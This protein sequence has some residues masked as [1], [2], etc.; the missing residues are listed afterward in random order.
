M[1]NVDGLPNEAG[2]IRE[3]VD[4]TLCY[5]KHS[6]RVQFAVTKLGK[7]KV[8]LGY[9]WLRKHNPEVDWVTQKVNLSRCPRVCSTCRAEVKAQRSAD[10][11][12]SKMEQQCCLGPFPKV[13]VEDIDDEEDEKYNHTAKDS[14]PDDNDDNALED[15]DRIFTTRFQ[16][17]ADI[18][19]TSTVS[20]RL[21]EAHAKNSTPTGNIPDWV[22]EYETVF[23]KESFDSLPDRRS[24]DHAIE[25]FPDA[26]P[27]N[28]KV[29]RSLP[30]SRRSLTASLKRDWHLVGFGHP[31]LPWEEQIPAPSDQ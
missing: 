25:L 6:K 28:C 16:S 8:I 20:Q 14:N 30:M 7:E 17:S 2:F 13:V 15:G 18:R 12:A 11:R 9:T 10:S 24:W 3:I 22:K 21:A 29:Y 19:A 23:A 1:F 4:V 27:K 26:E 31:S 5:Q